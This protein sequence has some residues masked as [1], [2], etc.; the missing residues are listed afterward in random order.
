[1]RPWTLS[2]ALA[3]L[4]SLSAAQ[5]PVPP[6]AWPAEGSPLVAP[7]LPS[8][9]R[10]GPIRMYLDA[11]H[12]ARGNT[13][14]RS[15]TCEDE[16]DFTFRLANEVAARLEATKRFRVKVSRGAGELVDYPSRLEAA[17]A[18]GAEVIV[19]LHSDARGAAYLWS[20]AEGLTCLRSDDDPGFGLLVSTEGSR[21]LVERRRA[22][23]G[24]VAARLGASGFLPY[25]G[26]NW[27][28]IYDPDEA[29]RGVFLDGRAHGRRLFFLRKTAIPSLILETHHALDVQEEARWGE[30][31]TRETFAEALAAGLAD[32]L[33]PPRPLVARR[34]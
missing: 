23:A 26:A 33:R 25:G 16:Q 24:A 30:A 29:R 10:G 21:R 17:A 6:P 27:L 14:N 2:P 15:V 31:R 22:I 7:A 13:G 20:P 9:G 28:K 32:A 8:F 12:G 34:R 18:F 1:M 4:T 3:L 5:E 11:G 19:S